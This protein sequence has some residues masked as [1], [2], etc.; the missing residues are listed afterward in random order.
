MKTI[1][2]LIQ[3]TIILGILLLPLAIPAYSAQ[4][5]PGTLDPGTIPK[6][7]N[8]ITGAPPVYTPEY[9]DPVT[10]AQY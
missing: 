10:G 9:V 1:T 7:V 2:K 4:V 6:Y 5:I 3:T 8:Q